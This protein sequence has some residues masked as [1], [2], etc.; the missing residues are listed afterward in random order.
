MCVTHLHSLTRHAPFRSIKV[1]ISP[2]VGCDN[3]WAH[4]L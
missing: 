3:A 2:L 1:Y 4:G